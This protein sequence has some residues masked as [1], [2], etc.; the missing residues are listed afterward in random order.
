MWTIAPARSANVSWT[1]PSFADNVGLL[2]STT[3]RQPGEYNAGVYQVTASASDTSGNQ[4][5]CTFNFTVLTDTTPPVISP[6]PSAQIAPCLYGD[7]FAIVSWPV[8]SVSDNQHVASIKYYPAPL[9]PG[10]SFP[11]G[12][13]QMTL[14]ATDDYNN[15][16]SKCRTCSHTRVSSYIPFRLLPSQCVLT[17]SMVG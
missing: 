3:S 8:P 13:T 1:L 7:S 9:G 11:I 12:S 14:V 6:C 16:K 4:M 2:S 5:S 17:K 10:S 15:T